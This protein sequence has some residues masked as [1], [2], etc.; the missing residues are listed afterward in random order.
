M[1][2]A[3]IQNHQKLKTIQT[4]LHWRMDKPTVI[5]PCNGAPLCNTNKHMTDILNNED[6]SQMYFDRSEQSQKGNA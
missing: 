3:L 4:S 2:I 1:Y 6:E 5:G